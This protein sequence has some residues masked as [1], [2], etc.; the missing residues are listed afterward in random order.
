MP[1]KLV[2]PGRGERMRSVS[3]A[4]KHAN[5]IQDGHELP[6]DLRSSRDLGMLS[7]ALRLR[8]VATLHPDTIML[9]LY[10]N[11]GR[12]VEVVC[13]SELGVDLP[14]GSFPL[15]RGVTSDV[16]RNQKSRLIR[17]WSEEAPPVQVQYLSNRPG[18]PQSAL[19][20][21][22]VFGD[23]TLGVIAAHKYQP[24]AFDEHDLRQLEDIAA[25]AG[26]VLSNLL[27]SPLVDAHLRRASELEGILG[28]LPEAVLLLD[29]EGRLLRLNRAARD[30]LCV[31]AESVVVG[32]RLQDY[33]WSEWTLGSAEISR[34]LIPVVTALQQGQVP[35][36]CELAVSEGRRRVL[37]FTGAP[38]FDPHG[39]PTGSVIVAR[40]V[41]QSRHIEQM[42][43]EM[44]SI[45]SHDLRTPV[46]V[47]RTEAQLLH[48]ELR[49]RT[50]TRPQIVEGI[51]SILQQTRKLSRLL[52]LLLDV[53]R[54]EAGRFEVYRTSVDLRAVAAR[55][56]DAIQATTE[57][58]RLVVTVSGETT[59]QWDEARIEQVMTN[60]LV[61]AVK[62]SPSGGPIILTIAGDPESVRLQVTDQ[63]VGLT[64][65]ESHHVF[66][67]YFRGGSTRRLEG[68]GLGLYICRS[69]VTAH[70]GRIWVESHGRGHG[71]TFSVELPRR[72]PTS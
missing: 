54:I 58:H 19:I 63:G 4:Q 16:I 42:K 48:R 49:K 5:G 69:I 39:E 65:E 33:V 57:K 67:R 26:T 61:N 50:A 32:Q 6:R 18:L 22:I 64:R 20:V 41:T 1:L 9:G 71:S 59:G 10:D 24:D 21:P 62:Y 25:E 53:S 2:R 68:S 38:L 56:T 51:G 15:G 60:L 43:D 72:A 17:H 44:L 28:A 66:E 29:R 52:G 47:I 37:S 55:V 45:A 46:T 12:T 11:I 13:Q 27:T 8:I 34:A 30:L 70:G 31:D 3:P 40:D 23:R 14:G 36:P 35:E 7:N